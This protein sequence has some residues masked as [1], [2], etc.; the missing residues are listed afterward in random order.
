MVF[1]VRF[2]TKGNRNQ[3]RS[4]TLDQLVDLLGPLG[5]FAP[6]TRLHNFF[7]TIS[8]RMWLSRLRSATRR[9]SLPF[10]SRS[11]RG[12]RNSRRPRT[13]YFFFNR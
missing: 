7:A 3:P 9:I 13:A 6:C 10:S 12:S 8:C 4:M 11:W 2:V 5:K 1:S